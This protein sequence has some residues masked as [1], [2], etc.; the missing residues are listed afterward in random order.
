MNTIDIIISLCILVPGVLIGLRKGF[1][2]QI[3]TILIL[4]VCAWASFH[5]SEAV[6][7]II[8][9][10]I[11]GSATLIKVLSF[12][13]IFLVV[14]IVLYLL[15]RLL[16]KII[17]DITGGSLD[18]ILGMILGVAKWT[19]LAALVISLLETLD[20]TFHFLD[21]ESIQASVV[22]RLLHDVADTVF[23]YISNFIAGKINA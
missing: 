21:E 17:K 22:Y 12:T 9:Q 11:N 5:F 14:Y 19:L 1:I 2:F 16:L 18:K 15:G 20:S 10:H 8:A 7:E 3:V 4:I 6:G 23:P 13:V